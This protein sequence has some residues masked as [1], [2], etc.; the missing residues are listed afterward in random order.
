MVILMEHIYQ[1]IKGI[2]FFLIFI[3]IISNLLGKS[4][5]KKYIGIITGMIL[6]L[7]V[8]TPLLKL[9]RLDDKF[10]FFYDANLFWGKR[11]ELTNQVGYME[12]SQNKAIINAYK[13]EIKG[14]VG[15]I[16]K[17]NDLYIVSLKLDLDED[18]GS[19]TYCYLNG[20]SL[21]ASYEAIDQK[22]TAIEPVT[23]EKIVVHQKEEKEKEEGKDNFSSPMEI[24]IKNILSDFYNMETDNINI[25]IQG[26]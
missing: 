10:N 3:T 20:L 24:H 17:Q 11:E 25:S 13:E 14:Q 6:I 8:I 23:I 22:D 18:V 21:V 2:I 19:D 16:L 15:T 1:W 9:F 12:E 4:D 7:L 26:G 5:F